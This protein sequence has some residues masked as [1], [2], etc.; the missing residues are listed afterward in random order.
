MKTESEARET[1]KKALNLVEAANQGQDTAPGKGAGK[2]GSGSASASAPP[3]T[4]NNADADHLH[5][6]LVLLDADP[7]TKC[8]RMTVTHLENSLKDVLEIEDNA[9]VEY[10]EAV[11]LLIQ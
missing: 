10:W 4:A 1:L 5:L 9:H 11:R 3:A 7:V 8:A 6:Q 2:S